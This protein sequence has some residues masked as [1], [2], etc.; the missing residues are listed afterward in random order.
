MEKTDEELVV[1]HLSGD[2]NAF[3]LLVQRHLKGVY[4]FAARSIHDEAEDIVQDTFLK[5]WKN[6]KKYKPRNAKFKTWLMRITRNTVIDYLRKKKSFVFSDFDGHADI[7]ISNISDSED[8]PD[9][10]VARAHDALHIETLLKKLSPEY[11]E[12]LLLRYMNQMTFG[13]IGEILDES[14]NTV[15]SRHHRGL[16]KLRQY[17]NDLHQNSM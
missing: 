3:A 1:D 11:R 9:E 7:N 17:I 16:I 2:S 6:L 10:I 14:I 4:S 5:V 8:L 12:V 13:E 15:K